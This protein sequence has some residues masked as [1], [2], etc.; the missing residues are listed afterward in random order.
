MTIDE[1]AKVYAK[2]FKDVTQKTVFLFEVERLLGKKY[3][4]EA[5]IAWETL[6][7]WEGTYR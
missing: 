2:G 6:D 5:Q 3:V 1:R 7:Q 4:Q